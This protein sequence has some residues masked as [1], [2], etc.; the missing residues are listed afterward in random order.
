MKTIAFTAALLLA[1][2]QLSAQTT[3]ETKTTTTEKADGS[4]TKTTT[5]TT[6]SGTLEAYEPGTRFV[7]KETSGPISYHYGP[8]VVYATRSGTVLTEEQIKTRI[9]VGVPVHVEFRPDGQ[10]KVVERV[11]IDD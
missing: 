8:K 3:T 11:V 6:S 1:A 9:K 2:G 10:T 7:V 5:S 4:V